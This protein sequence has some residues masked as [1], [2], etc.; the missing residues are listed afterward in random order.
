LKPRDTYVGSPIVGSG[1]FLM[2]DVVG[3][4]KDKTRAA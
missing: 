4:L 2:V 1:S 3:V